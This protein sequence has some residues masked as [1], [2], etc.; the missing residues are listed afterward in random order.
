MKRMKQLA[1]GCMSMVLVGVSLAAA[2]QPQPVVRLGD[3][4]EI[5]NELFM[6]FITT[7]DFR[8][9]TAQNYD[10][11]DDIRDR[12]PERDP[13]STLTGNQEFDGL[14]LQAQIGA[15]FRFQKSLE[16]R[17]LLR[18]ETVQDGNLSDGRSA[19][20]FNPGGTDVFGRDAENEA[21]IW[22]LE[23]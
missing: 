14:R 15:D 12:V 2:Q 7:L 16:A 19:N 8:Y 9:V 18:H 10:F 21:D 4:V 11:E 3:W 5:G 17:I 13:N 1:L 6:N 23:R 20:D 22:N